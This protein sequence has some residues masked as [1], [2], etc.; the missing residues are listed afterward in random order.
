M[1]KLSYYL[2]FFIAFT[3][4]VQGNVF[5]QSFNFKNEKVESMNLLGKDFKD[6]ITAN[7]TPIDYWAPNNIYTITP[8]P[9]QWSAISTV[10]NYPSNSAEDR[11]Q[12]GY[13]A[14]ANTDVDLKQ[15]RSFVKLEVL[16]NDAAVSVEKHTPYVYL[17]AL[18]VACFASYTSC[19]P[20]FKDDTLMISYLPDG[21]YAFQDINMKSYYG[22]YSIQVQIK[23][24]YDVTDQYYNAN[25]LG[26]PKGDGTFYAMKGSCAATVTPGAVTSYTNGWRSLINNNVQGCKFSTNW[27][28]TVGIEY[29]PFVKSITS[30]IPQ[31]SFYANNMANIVL[32]AGHTAPNLSANNIL[33]VDW[34]TSNNHLEP[35]PALYELEWTYV[36]NYKV[37]YSGAMNQQATIGEISASNLTYNFEENAT[38]VI[39]DK[40]TYD[41]PL[42]YKRG[43]IVYRV[44]LVR[45]DNTQYKLSKYSEWSM[46]ATGV[47]SNI[48]QNNGGGYPYYKFDNPHVD[49]NINWNYQISYAEQGKNKNVI[50][51][52]DGLLKNRQS[53]T[54][55]GSVPNQLIATEP[56]YN[57]EG[58]AGLQSLPIPIIKDPLTDNLSLT[59]QNNFL[60][61][62]H[63]AAASAPYKAEDI[64]AIGGSAVDPLDNT[65][66]ASKYYSSANPLLSLYNAGS[67][68]HNIA[69]AIPDAEAFPFVQ[70]IH[71]EDD[72]SR[73]K[74]QGGAGSQLQIGQGHETR[75]YYMDPLQTE[76][77]QYLGLNGGIFKFYDKTVTR[78]PNKQLSFSISN[79]LGKPVMTGLMQKPSVTN[80]PEFPLVTLDKVNPANAVVTTTDMMY[81]LSSVWEGNNLKFNKTYMNEGGDNSFIY[82]VKLDAF[83]PC[84]SA[85]DKI[86]VPLQMEAK[87]RD[88]LPG[89]HN[90]IPA[91]PALTVSPDVNNQINYTVANPSVINPE[92]GEVIVDYKISYKPEDL[93][94]AVDNFLDPHSQPLVLTQS[95]INQLPCIESYNSYLASEL[96]NIPE[97]CVLPPTESYSE[98]AE[99]EKLMKDQLVPG[100]AY[101]KYEKLGNKMTVVGNDTSMFKIVGWIDK[102][103]YPLPTG[104]NN[105]TFAG[106]LDNYEMAAGTIA[107]PNNLYPP[108]SHEINFTPS[109]LPNDNSFTNALN[110][111]DA[112]SAET[113]REK[114][115]IYY[116]M[117]YEKYQP[118]YLYQMYIDNMPA[119]VQA[120]RDLLVQKPED[121]IAA[122][123]TDQI[124]EFVK[125]HPEYCMLGQVYCETE[126]GI[127]FIDQLENVNSYDVAEDFH[128]ETLEKLADSDPLK[129]WYF[130]N[131]N[132]GY[133]A[134]LKLNIPK[135]GNVANTDIPLDHYACLQTYIE[136][137]PDEDYN[138]P[139]NA[140][141]ITFFTN[142]A[143]NNPVTSQ[144]FYTPINASAVLKD[145]YY[146]KLKT[147][148]LGARRK[149]ILE[150]VSIN[151][152][153]PNN[154]I[155]YVIEANSI[156]RNLI[157]GADGPGYSPNADVAAALADYA[158]MDPVDAATVEPI[159]N[160]NRLKSYR[161]YARYIVG[162]LRNCMTTASPQLIL[163]ASVA[164]PAKLFDAGLY[165]GF[166]VPNTL[167]EQ[168]ELDLAAFMKMNAGSVA[169][170][171][172]KGGV[173]PDAVR[174]I[175]NQRGVN[176]DDLCNPYL[177]S[178]ERA[179]DKGIQG[180]C[181]MN[182]IWKRISEPGNA[183]HDAKINL[184]ENAKNETGY[185][186]ANFYQSS[187]DISVTLKATGGASPVDKLDDLIHFSLGMG[188]SNEYDVNLHYEYYNNADAIE[189]LYPTAKPAAKKAAS[190]MSGS[191][192]DPF[193]QSLEYTFTNTVNT[194]DVKFLFEKETNPALSY[195]GY[196]TC[197]SIGSTCAGAVGTCAGPAAIFP[198]N[199]VTDFINVNPLLKE[200]TTEFFQYNASGVT[201]NG[202]FYLYGCTPDFSEGKVI[203][204]VVYK[205]DY[206]EETG[207]IYCPVEAYIFA[208]KLT[209]T[210]LDLSFL[211]QHDCITAYE[212]KRD[213]D[214]YEDEVVTPYAIKGPKHPF[215]EKT[216]QN[217]YN[218]NF[219][220]SH[221][222]KKYVDFMDGAHLAKHR[223]LP[224]YHSYV[225]AHDNATKITDLIEWATNTYTVTAT[226]VVAGVTSTITVHPAKNIEYFRFTENS[227]DHVYFNLNSIKS[228]ETL[229]KFL[230]ALQAK[231]G[232]GA[233]NL[234]ISNFHV[235]KLQSE[236]PTPLTAK[237]VEVFVNGPVTV[238][239]IANVTYIPPGTVT[240]KHGALSAP[241]DKHTFV[242]GGGMTEQAISDAIYEIK[243]MSTGECAFVYMSTNYST[244]NQ[245]N[246]TSA[247]NAYLDQ[248]YGISPVVNG[249]PLYIYDDIV[250]L[251]KKVPLLADNLGTGANDYHSPSY[252]SYLSP[253]TMPATIAVPE[254]DYISGNLYLAKADATP[255]TY[256]K[257]FLQSILTAMKTVLGGSLQSEYKCITYGNNSP[258]STTGSIFY[259][260]SFYAGNGIS[261]TSINAYGLEYPSGATYE[262][263]PRRQEGNVYWFKIKRS[264]VIAG[265]VPKYYNIYIKVPDHI[266]HKLLGAYTPDFGTGFD[267]LTH[268]GGS[269]G[270]TINFN[271]AGNNCTAANSFKAYGVTDFLLDNSAP[272]VFEK[273]MLCDYDEDNGLFDPC[274]EEILA[275]A[276]NNAKSKFASYIETK[277]GELMAEMKQHIE[278]TLVPRLTLTNEQ[279]KYALTLY[280]YDR[281]GNLIYTV[282][283][284]GVAQISDQP[285]LDDIDVK[286]LQLS[287]TIIDELPAHKK[288]SRYTYNTLN[289]LTAQSTPD[290]GETKFFY[291]PSGKLAFSQ[292]A[293]QAIYNDFSY[294]L[295]DDQNR[296]IE[297]GQIKAQGGTHPVKQLTDNLK[298]Y[299][300][301]TQLMNNANTFIRDLVR[302]YFRREVVCTYYDEPLY[303]FAT[304]DNSMSK[305][306]NMRSRVA[307]IA[308]YPALSANPSASVLQ[309]NFTVA[310]HYSYDLSG[311]V[312]TLTYDMPQLDYLK[313]RYKRI[314]YDYDLYSGKVNLVSYNRGFTDQYYQQYDYDD[315]NRITNVKTSQDGLLWDNDADYKYYPHGPLARVILG[316]LTVQ[317]IDFAYTLQG[318]LKSINGDQPKK[319]HDMGGDGLG[320]STTFDDKLQ[321]TLYYY[322]GDYKAIDQSDAN[323][324][325]NNEMMHK[326]ED[327]PAGRSLY[328]GN[329]SSALTAP[330]NFDP[331]FTEYWYDQLNRI[332]KATYKVPDYNG[333]FSYA[334]SLKYLSAANANAGY[335]ANAGVAPNLSADSMYQ[336]E[337]NYDLDG[338]LTHLRRMGVYYPSGA[339]NLGGLP[340]T[341]LMDNINY[342]Y[343]NRDINGNLLGNN[344]P[345]NRLLNYD[346]NA[347]HAASSLFTNDLQQYTMGNTDPNVSPRFK[348]DQTGNLIEDH[349]N[350]K[351][352][353]SIS[354]TLYGKVSNIDYGLT[355]HSSFLYEPGGNR[356]RKTHI[357]PI[358][359]YNPTPGQRHLHEYYIRD[360]SGN[361]LAIYKHRQDFKMLNP[362][363][364]LID[365][366]KTAN[367]FAAAMASILGDNAAF[368]GEL[369]TALKTSHNTYFNAMVAAKTPSYY[370]EN[371]AVIKKAMVEQTG[372]LLPDLIPAHP[373]LFKSVLHTVDAN[374]FSP[375]FIES[376]ASTQK[377]FISLLT[378]TASSNLTTMQ[379]ILA[380]V[381]YKRAIANGQDFVNNM[382][383]TLT[384]SGGPAAQTSLVSFFATADTTVWYPSLLRMISDSLYVNKS[385]TSFSYGK[386]SNFVRMMV[387]QN[388]NTA[389]LSNY[390]TAMGSPAVGILSAAATAYDRSLVIF[391]VEP[392]SLFS[393]LKSETWFATVMDE[394]LNKTTNLSF[395]SFANAAIAN[396]D[397]GVMAASYL[398]P[399]IQKDEYYLAEHHLYG[400]SRL[401]I[402]NYWPNHYQFLY[403]YTGTGTWNDAVAG[404]QLLSLHKPWYSSVYNS[405][406]GANYVSPYGHANTDPVVSSRI[407]G[408]KHLELTNHLGNV[409]TV[410]TDKIVDSTSTNLVSDG[411]P[412]ASL[413][414]ASVYAT[415]DYYPFGMLMPNRYA[416]DNTVQCTPVTKTIYHPNWVDIGSVVIASPT[417]PAAFS[418]SSTGTATMSINTSNMLVV[419]TATSSSPV[420]TTLTYE[421]SSGVEAFKGVK[422]SVPVTNSTTNLLDI[423]L[424]QQDENNNWVAFAST[425][426]S[427][428]AT[429]VLEGTP[430]SNTAVRAV[431]SGT[432]AGFK[433]GP[434]LTFERHDLLATT[435]IVQICNNNDFTRDY[436]FGFNGKHKD[437]E[438]KGTGNNYDYG[439][440]MYDSRLGRPLS[441]DPLQKSYPNLTPYQFFSNNPIMN[442][443][444]DGL[445]GVKYSEV[446][447]NA[448]TGQTTIKTVV[449]V[450]VYV[451]IDESKESA[452]YKSADIKNIKVD[453]DNYYNNGFSDEAGNAVE[454]RFMMKQF[455][456]SSG[457]TS[458]QMARDLAKDESNFETSVSGMQ[459][460]RYITLD[461]KDNISGEGETVQMMSTVSSK[462]DDPK[463]T[464][465]HEVG[466]ALLYGDVLNDGSG[467]SQKVHNDLGGMF[468]Y[469]VVDEDNGSTITPT[470][471]MDQQNSNRIL[472]NTPQ[473]KTRINY[474][475]PTEKPNIK[476]APTK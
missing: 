43:Y 120:M 412:L 344:P 269:Y 177:I 338:N 364:E 408:L 78:D 195:N 356:F 333:T 29:Q 165:T 192:I 396:V 215:Y 53:L 144:G 160:G 197:S 224:D 62:D 254:A 426:L 299:N 16:Y 345:D 186:G 425:T 230:L 212:F 83:V 59:Y 164:S 86:N 88:E 407:I 465:S 241:F 193:P 9:C 51:Y 122:G 175:L 461:R 21:N 142:V 360:A 6:F 178:Y 384:G 350:P 305:Q 352:L 450:D 152:C 270:F 342:Y 170:Y 474:I 382:Y 339:P 381:G 56:V 280:G 441:V 153:T 239:T 469:K 11:I 114:W 315:D 52:F 467:S 332:R 473:I 229:R 159:E 287:P 234:N 15:L 447:I 386:L 214:K 250:N 190:Y 274:F 220:K 390:Y 366:I 8:S 77:N 392:E 221:E 470:Q 248:A 244:T 258:V 213:Y 94:A 102:T 168:I 300:F 353:S 395:A 263:K 346:E 147:L 235:N 261:Y 26:V 72:H 201:D 292:N 158:T 245:V 435:E 327:I 128:L 12:A 409:M 134:L 14:N 18:K 113:W 319:E 79:N 442:I 402:K 313:Q 232:P 32:Q 337:Y 135:N 141:Y 211:K 255:N 74:I 427:S 266:P 169:E 351:D 63:P 115:G 92:V 448:N 82:G 70:T 357:I 119:Q 291:D 42:I 7:Q 460:P 137:F 236:L 374:M 124:S 399:K 183:I 90:I 368:A 310:Q 444:L 218:Y 307:A 329:I 273:V 362:F 200:Y 46:P 204:N 324:A 251:V 28:L 103:N 314:D 318:W 373:E 136:A 462:A 320:N 38:R 157:N 93:E 106:D 4:Y 118:I 268:K 398:L 297:T 445:E 404:N 459:V 64:D 387:G 13:I 99:Y 253:G 184:M 161:S 97:S 139:S 222:A 411:L 421:V 19:T 198:A 176:M 66:L 336:S 323:L 231:A 394:A 257:S 85:T 377:A 96:N 17:V 45:P 281:A 415:Y 187:P 317:G 301:S 34:K 476:D 457:M 68:E 264:N 417:V 434:A 391:D 61:A 238:P 294:T 131:I 24:V 302:G 71:A 347:I 436:R 466:H 437:N 30:G 107:P 321:H 69:K 166:P 246:T 47:I 376:N 428:S 138:D 206:H 105:M 325:N 80:P 108:A 205:N 304:A 449:E 363:L 109:I 303:E 202:K 162:Q 172:W 37:T 125:M 378:D 84:S 199:L 173:T 472:G 210:G 422:L 452:H 295:Y 283:P 65:S 60:I 286:R 372:S 129:A 410:L 419:S 156:F 39:T 111:A 167:W 340:K 259:K 458:L 438:V 262:I 20:V 145:K 348:Y 40:T 217:F 260:N 117:V 380:A 453:L 471:R 226:T 98:C 298:A 383:S 413:R 67:Q 420:T 432:K 418:L 27:R 116:D 185:P 151:P 174:N 278:T 375:L 25:S 209:I 446:T 189:N 355:E 188:G 57:F 31:N 276:E 468:K 265:G 203:L 76:L 58:A 179:L 240:F 171:T 101:A 343:T 75:F 130:A 330:G 223:L 389:T 272:L 154:T 267:I 335:L 359:D 406:I 279:M 140:N 431:F 228:D 22:F 41:I 249:Q 316:D 271:A 89:V 150:Q 400:S 121:L 277:K 463:H 439:M 326:I 181:D 208:L 440:R 54:K 475:R 388:G 143:N 55:F 393:T 207:G 2:L 293:K 127:A 33:K 385:Y 182:D 148:Y 191:P 95:E 429:I 361:I 36:D 312:K 369:M 10:Q 3:F 237:Y 285:T 401:G 397:V 311:N 334:N 73:V 163:N 328:N 275:E 216:L 1:K 44:R 50:S 365:G 133:D 358:T 194:K 87:L 322:E 110:N 403:D 227:E 132:N 306:E 100:S 454:Y 414:K 416:E 149:I 379:N 371:S 296:I 341:Y 456:A 112:A 464:V 349:T 367:G 290:A 288:L 146:K 443:D 243:K 430:L 5:A 155:P 451:A 180:V 123:I 81:G 219:M 308:T 282:P 242:M 247:K 405:L 309:N 49:D 354:W 455:D 126:E 424:Q 433:I 252:L 423:S 331:L 225:Q 370:L 104:F 256:G 196:Y 289:Q 23:D 233:G 48:S 91:P 35:V 284:E